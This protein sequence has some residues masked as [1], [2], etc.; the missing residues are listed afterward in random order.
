M[1]IGIVLPLF[2]AIAC[3][4]TIATFAGNGTAGYKGDGGQAAQA[5]V[6]YVTGLASDSAGNIYLADQ[7][8]NAVRKVDT[9]G[10]ITTIAGTGMGGFAGD[11]GPATSAFLSLPSG[12]CVGPSGD[13]YVN[14]LANYRVR[15]ISAATGIITT[16]AGSG[17]SIPSGDGGPAISAGMKIPIRCAVDSSGNLYIVDQ[18][19]TAN[20]VRKVDGNGMISTVAGVYGGTGF[21]GDGG[22]AIKATMFNLT[23]ITI[24]ASGN[25]YL[26]DQGDQRIRKVD[27]NGIITTVAGNG[28]ASFGGDGGAATAASLNYPGETAVDAAGNLF[29]ADIVNNVIRKVSGGTISTVAGTPSSAG[30]SGDGGPPLQ[31]KLNN[32]FALTLDKAG[33]MYVADTTDNVV[34]KITGVAGGTGPSITVTGN[35][36]GVTN[37]ASFQA[38]IAPGGIVTIFGTNLGASSGQTLIA[39]GSPWPGQ[40]G[41]TAVAMN[42]IAAPVYYVLN[43]NG[44][45]QLS[46][47]APWSLS[48][49]N[50]ATVTVS[51]SAGT[52]TAVTVP[53]LG[54][55]PGIFLLDAASSGATH[56]NGK[57]AGASNPATRG[58]VVVMY[59]TGMGPVSNQPASGV[60]ASL[61]VLSSTS[62]TPTVTIG[63]FNASVAF[64]GLAPGF[65]GTYQINVTI[66]SAVASGVVDVTVQANGVTSNTAK[67]AVQ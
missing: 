44:Q 2:A 18:G 22:P 4:Q 35:T 27:T 56:V 51:T 3:G 45:E 8:N 67:I 12:V 36:V 14:D 48:G 20:V 63:G 37:A 60:A 21:S 10:V 62:L 28:T 11:G 26:T 64:S 23:A 7:N 30:Y 38:G 49:V 33:N 47:Q 50:S 13:V 40:L 65:I 55:Q 19:N 5:L 32:P 42:G 34:R 54:A 31:A 46:V 15:K 29:I 43:S 16:V 6:N 24:D 66:P 58:E 41:T 52:S 61:T 39:P 57:V 59:L 17:S 25:L 9:H 53:V 1:K